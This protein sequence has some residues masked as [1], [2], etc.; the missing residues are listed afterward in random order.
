MGNT[1]Y[2]NEVSIIIQKASGSEDIVC[3][4]MEMLE[5]E[6]FICDIRMNKLNQEYKRRQKI[7]RNIKRFLFL[8]NFILFDLILP[9][10]FLVFAFT[11]IFLIITYLF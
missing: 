7:K 4:V 1:N 11:S 6:K 5:D 9:I 8:F 10:V 3:V 2:R